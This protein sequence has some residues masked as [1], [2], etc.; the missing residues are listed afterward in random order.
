[1]A[2]TKTVPA[3][4][5][6]SN[7]IPPERRIKLSVVSGIL[8][9]GIIAVMLFFVGQE[10]PQHQATKE[11][12]AAVA[13][14][15]QVPTDHISY[16]GQTGSNALTLLKKTAAVEQDA[17]GL[18][19]SINGRKADNSNHEFWAFVVNGKEAMVGPADYQTKE[20]DQIEWKIEKY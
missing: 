14:Q 4:D 1:M 6:P 17:S 20:S 2:K 7:T 9:A 18:V 15:E 10:Q 16:Q 8:F 19:V 3:K 13:K 11:Q 12:P 5:V